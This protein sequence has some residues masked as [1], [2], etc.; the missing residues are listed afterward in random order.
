M[1]ANGETALCAAA[2][3]GY[4]A[5]AML[6]LNH[7]VYPNANSETGSPPF[8]IAAQEV[9]QEVVALHLVGT[10]GLSKQSNY[11]EAP[12]HLAA[13]KGRKSVVELP[14]ANNA[15]VEARDKTDASPFH[16]ASQIKQFNKGQYE[17]YD[18][19]PAHL[20]DKATKRTQTEF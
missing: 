3:K 8:R 7:M 13:T 11:G 18:M 4:A 19:E 12:A 1:N 20:H 2:L 5:V 10:A 6:L 17:Q 15:Q 16:N 9:Q 14:L